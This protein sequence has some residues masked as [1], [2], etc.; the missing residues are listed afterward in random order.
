MAS[1]ADHHSMALYPQ[2]RREQGN[3]Y[4]SPPLHSGVF[5]SSGPMDMSSIPADAFGHF[6][7]HRAESQQDN[8][9]TPGTTAMGYEPSLFPDATPN[10]ILNGRASPTVY[11]DDGDVRFP[12]GLSSGSVPSAPSSVIGSPQ[13]NSGNLHGLVEWSNTA[14]NHAHGLGV[15]PS[16]VNSDYMELSPYGLDDFG[17]AFEFPGVVPAKSFVG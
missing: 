5:P 11:G 10:Y 16:I 6:G 12:S 3:R 1:L 2:Q 14:T 4:P 9:S 15:Q 7:G 8:Y 13:S 17:A